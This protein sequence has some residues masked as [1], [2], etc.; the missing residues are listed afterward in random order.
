MT[1]L[2]YTEILVRSR[3]E[4][5]LSLPGLLAWAPDRRE[6]ASPSALSKPPRSGSPARGSARMRSSESRPRRGGA[7]L[8]AYWR[9]HNWKCD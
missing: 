2:I 7:V 8:G 4:S 1:H 9:K 6:S 5:I 3:L